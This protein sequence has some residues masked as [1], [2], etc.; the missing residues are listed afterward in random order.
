MTSTMT[1]ST[2]LLPSLNLL[3]PRPGSST[4][5][6]KPSQRTLSGFGVRYS[7]FI[8]IRP[9][10]FAL[11]FVLMGLSRSSSTYLSGTGYVLSLALPR[12]PIV[13]MRRFAWLISGISSATT[14]PSASLPKS[15]GGMLLPSPIKERWPSTGFQRLFPT[16]LRWLHPRATSQV[17]NVSTG[18]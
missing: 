3:P 6:P 9:V 7:C 14:V 5:L 2:N 8:A 15:L 1:P 11:P 12:P 16:P 13:P 10:L 18:L 4:L 17:M